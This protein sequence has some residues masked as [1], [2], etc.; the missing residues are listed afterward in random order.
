ME[1]FWTARTIA[2]PLRAKVCA[3]SRSVRRNNVFTDGYSLT[4]SIVAGTVMR[5][6]A[7]C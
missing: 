5:N 3:A 4:N 2:A 6:T 7:D 1:Q